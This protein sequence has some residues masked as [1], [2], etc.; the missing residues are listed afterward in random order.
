EPIAYALVIQST[1]SANFKSLGATAMSCIA[2]SCDS[3][4]LTGIKR[5]QHSSGPDVP[6]A[7]LAASV[8][9]LFCQ[10]PYHRPKPSPSLARTNAWC[11]R[12]ANCYAALRN[13]YVPGQAAL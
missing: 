8:S 1:N 2:C 12:R 11:K 13:L 3:H 4:A 9:L 6:D 7:T 10:S 5:S